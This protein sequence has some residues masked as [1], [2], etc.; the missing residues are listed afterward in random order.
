MDSRRRSGCVLS[1]TSAAGRLDS[2]SRQRDVVALHYHS[3]GGQSIQSAVEEIK[4]TGGRVEAFQADFTDVAQAKGLA[5]EAIAFLGGLDVLV[6]NAGTTMNRPFEKVTVEQYDTIYNV[7]VRSMFFVTQAALP[8]LTTRHNGVIINMAS[9]H[10]FSGIIE[11]TVYAGT[12]GAIVAFTRTLA[13]ELASKG[14]RVNAIAPGAV[15]V[16][17]HWKVFGESFD[18]KA[19]G[20]MNPAGFIGDPRDIGRLCIF[21]ASDES[22]YIMGQTILCDGGLSTIMPSRE[23]F[24]A[25]LR[26]QFGKGYVPGL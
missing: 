11:H 3:H 10:A 22:R 19:A 8:A 12:K 1:R 21:L 17:N 4:T 25:P 24:R 20:K 2:G 26:E 14:V 16:E 23:D 13:L 18:P 9:N 7:N 5:G 6:N 15:L